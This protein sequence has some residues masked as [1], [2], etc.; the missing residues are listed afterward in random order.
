ME[1]T[2]NSKLE[3]RARTDQQLNIR[4][5]NQKWPTVLSKV[6]EM[7]LT[8][9]SKLEER[10]RADQQFKVRGANWIWPTIEL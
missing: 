1:L 8:K 4:G 2:K 10:T 6:C 7:E 9:N 5:M 3:E